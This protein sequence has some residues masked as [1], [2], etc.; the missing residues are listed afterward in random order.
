MNGGFVFRAALTLDQVYDESFLADR[1]G[2]CVCVCVYVCVCEGA[3]VRN[4]LNKV[5]R[6]LSAYELEAIVGALTQL[7]KAT[8]S[9]VMSICPSIY[10]EQ[11]GFHGKDFHEI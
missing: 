10:K 4:I 11:L 8:I 6:S 3:V 5:D 1:V 2:V 9:F 7:R